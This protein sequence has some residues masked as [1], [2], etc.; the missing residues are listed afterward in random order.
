VSTLLDQFLTEGAELLDDATA[1]LLE[2]ERR[3]G[4]HDLLNGVFRAAHTFKGSSGLFDYVE[5]T[6]VMHAAED[7]LDVLRRGELDLDAQ[8]VDDVMVAIDLARA[9][10]VAIESAGELPADAVRDGE[11][12]VVRLRARVVSGEVPG[13]TVATPEAGPLPTPAWALALATVPAVAAAVAAGTAVRAVRYVPDAGCFFRAEDPLRLVREIPSLLHLVI[14]REGS[15]PSPDD[16]DEYACALQ[17]TLATEAP[18]EVLD[19]LLRYVLDEIAVHELSTSVP[20]EPDTTSAAARILL[21]AQR[22]ALAA[23]C[24]PEDEAI[25]LRAIADTVGRALAIDGRP[26]ESIRPGA[27]ALLATPDRA[28]LVELLDALDAGSPPAS[29]ERSIDRAEAPRLEAVAAVAAEAPTRPAPAGG[30]TVKVEQHKLDHLL[31]LVGELVVAKNALP[32]LARA[33]EDGQDARQLARS[34]KDQHVALNRLTEELQA[35]AMGMRMLP[36]SVV[37]SRFPRMVRDTARKLGKQVR[38]ETFGEETA[39]DKDVLEQLGDP[40]VHLVRN[41]LDHGLEGPEERL[42]AGKPAEGTI[43]LT[44]IQQPDGVVIELRDDGRGIDAAVIRRVAYAKGLISEQEAESLDDSAARELLFRPGFST[45]A[46]VSDLSGRGVGMDAVLTTIVRLGG[47]VSLESELGV[48]TTMRLRLPLSMAVTQMMV[49]TAGG[50]QFGVPVDVVRETVRLSRTDLQSV[51]R[52]AATVR[53]GAVVPVID[54]AGALGLAPPDPGDEASREAE[55]D[56]GSDDVRLLVV[57]SGSAEAALIVDRFEEYLDVIVKPLEGVLAGLP[58]ISGSSL[59]GNGHVL[60]I[61]DVQETL[62]RAHAS[63]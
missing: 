34:I 18:V 41:S 2:L 9:W 59:L 38:L 10:L 16:F 29:A 44:A 17:F 58:G 47:S 13:G 23:P 31:E 28:G 49:V 11:A 60:L 54:L 14:D 5:L 39:A 1:G 48:G 46:E 21:D 37:F 22:R 3:P 51:G 57:R 12:C 30:R 45:A 19:D 50:Q 53:R 36:V 61:L 24:P 63:S 20:V 26:A 27:E 33:A 55:P 7:V 42:A 40:L 32:F 4:D 56:D 8:L 43:T 52:H 15:W 25:R 35:T 62:N 6:R